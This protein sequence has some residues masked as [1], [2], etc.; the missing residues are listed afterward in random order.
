MG[1]QWIMHLKDEKFQES[2]DETLKT[3]IINY[4]ESFGGFRSVYKTSKKFGVDKVKLREMGFE[5]KKETVLSPDFSEEQIVHAELNNPLSEEKLQQIVD[6]L[7]K[8]GGVMTFSELGVA[9]GNIMK[10]QLAFHFD[11]IQSSDGQTEIRIPGVTGSIEDLRGGEKPELVPSLPDDLLKEITK[12]LEK[13]GGSMDSEDLRDL[14]PHVKKQQLREHF[15]IEMTRKV[16]ETGKRFYSVTIRGKRNSKRAQAA[17]QRH[18]DRQIYDYFQ[19]K[20]GPPSYQTDKGKHKGHT[21]A[22]S[23]KGEVHH[24]EKGM[25]KGRGKMAARPF[26][27]FGSAAGA[28]ESDAK[29]QRLAPGK[30]KSDAKHQFG[31]TGGAEYEY[32]YAKGLAKGATFAEYDHWAG[33]GAKGLAKGAA[34]SEYDHWAGK[35]A[36]YD[37]WYGK[38]KAQGYYGMW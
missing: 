16:K 24:A 19:E 2:L 5:V 9:A 22:A 25:E 32:W 33:K 15:D 20:N 17:V 38:G 37:H 3:E 13:H 30:G 10:A 34:F 36:E 29:R 28:G 1:G 31:K 4:L 8:A 21:G 12:V 35:G 11:V 23:A 6:L 26:T 14:Y 7:S 18:T 27:A